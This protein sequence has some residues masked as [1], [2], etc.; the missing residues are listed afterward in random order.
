MRMEPLEGL[1][2]IPMMVGNEKV[3]AI[4]KVNSNEK[5]KK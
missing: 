2:K 1:A 5:V 4:L 3:M